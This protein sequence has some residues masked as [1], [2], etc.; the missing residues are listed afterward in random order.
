M[1]YSKALKNQAISEIVKTVSDE[2]TRT[3]K[4]ELL[5]EIVKTIKEKVKYGDFKV[6]DLIDDLT[7]DITLTK[8]NLMDA[9][10]ST[11]R[12][13][14][15]YE[16]EAE[17]KRHGIKGDPAI[18]KAVFEAGGH[19]VKPLID[20]QGGLEIIIEGPFGGLGLN[21]WFQKAAIHES[22]AYLFGSDEPSQ[23]KPEALINPW[24]KG[25]FNLTKQGEVIKAN[26]ALAARFKTEAGLP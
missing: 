9:E 7:S 10:K 20:S 15:G 8:R 18:I 21:Q 14:A 11:L 2:A 19:Q 22:T 17:A 3:A 1:K 16:I 6:E 5:T 24:L 13:L 23:K 4:L 12:A 25:S 26:P